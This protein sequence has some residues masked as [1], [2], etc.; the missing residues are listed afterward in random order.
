MET[1]HHD[2]VLKYFP[3]DISNIPPEP[4]VQTPITPQPISCIAMLNPYE[5]DFPPLERRINQNTRIPS[6]PYVTPTTVDAQGNYQ[7]IQVEEVLNWQTQN[8]VCQNKTLIRIDS[9]L[10]SLAIKTDA[11][12]FQI[13]Q[14]SEEV[15]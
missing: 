1:G 10:D 9:K 15:K 13:E 8:A 6:K 2:L 14:M 5:Q 4:F 3:N 12:T 11:L 7:S